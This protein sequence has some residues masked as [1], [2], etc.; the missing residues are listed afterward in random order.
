MDKE[1]I[2]EVRH[3]NARDI[4]C[5]VERTLGLL[6]TG[7]LKLVTCEGCQAAMQQNKKGG[8]K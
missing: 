4:P 3:F 5:G 7:D 1:E 6:V 8:D 2:Q